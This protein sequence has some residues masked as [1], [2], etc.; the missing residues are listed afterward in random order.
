MNDLECGT[1]MECQIAVVQ[2]GAHTFFC[3][4][5]LPP[6]TLNPPAVGRSVRR[7]TK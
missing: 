2:L 4:R 1:F 3:H 5:D 7:V 6:L